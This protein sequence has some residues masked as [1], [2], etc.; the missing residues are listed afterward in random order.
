MG[1]ELSSEVGESTPPKT[2]KSRN[3]SGLASY[4]ISKNATKIVVMVCVFHWESVL[5]Y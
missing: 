3:I 1:N 5:T 4:I 2:L